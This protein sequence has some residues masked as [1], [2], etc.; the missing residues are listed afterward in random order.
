MIGFCPLASG[1]KGNCLYLGIENTKILIDLG[2]TKTGLIE[3]LQAIAV[4]PEEID[5]VFIS[6]EHWDHISGLKTF[7]KAFDVPVITNLETAQA[8][9]NQ[10][11]FLPKFK[12]FSTGSYFDFRDLRIKS[13]N[14]CHDAID[15]VG[16]VIE[17]GKFKIGICTDLGHITPPVKQ[18]LLGCDYLYLE[19][20]HD[21][22]MVHNSNRSTVHKN[23]ILS[24]MGHLSN[25][26]C[27]KIL[28]IIAGP[29]LRQVYLAH[30]SEECNSRK[31][32][33]E[34]VLSYTKELPIK[35][36]IAE[37]HT[38]SLPCYFECSNEKA[39]KNFFD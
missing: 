38:I 7:I 26:D 12:I 13:F 19:S 20:N 39:L 34:T 22:A 14:T 24:K 16:F 23:R 28:Q 32:A 27:G 18:G 2:I 29:Q 21:V 1:S 4:V 35:I 30:L 11:D 37:Q 33:L 9:Y 17:T 25:E 15:P 31:K 8:V 6:H 5:A 10:L 36:T 3:R